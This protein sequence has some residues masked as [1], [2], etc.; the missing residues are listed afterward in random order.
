VPE[1]DLPVV[2]PQD[3][4]FTGVGGSPLSKVEEFVNTTCPKCGKPAK[5]ETDTM[6]TFVDSS[7]YFLRYCDPKN[8]KLP[9]DKEKVDYWMPV[10]IYIG[11]IEHAVLHLLYSRFFTKFLKDI[12]LV[13]VDEPFEKLLTQGMVLKKWI[14]IGKLLEILGVDENI[15]VDEFKEKLEEL[16]SKR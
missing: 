12:G 9:F 6:D 7:W 16:V 8:D 4:E 3:V 1:E 11:G 15:S 13:S 14:S 10:D 5:R 2:L